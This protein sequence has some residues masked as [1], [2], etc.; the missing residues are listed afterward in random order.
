MSIFWVS[1]AAGAA[2][3]GSPALSPEPGSFASDGGG[4]SEFT[5]AF[6]E[7][8]FESGDLFFILGVKSSL[9]KHTRRKTDDGVFTEFVL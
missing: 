2:G 1:A 3:A 5:T 8:V 9:V 6:N 7:L 4:V